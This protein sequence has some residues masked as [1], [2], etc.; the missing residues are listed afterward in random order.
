MGLEPL[1]LEVYTVLIRNSGK[2]AFAVSFLKTV[3][4]TILLKIPI[5]RSEVTDYVQKFPSYINNDA[6]F[7]ERC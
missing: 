6:C 1:R 2:R 4:K 3:L 5:T 7:G